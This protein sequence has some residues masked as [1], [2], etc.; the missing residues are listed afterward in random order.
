MSF[1]TKK[2]LKQG[3]HGRSVKNADEGRGDPGQ[4]RPERTDMAQGPGTKASC[5]HPEI[6]REVGCQRVEKSVEGRKLL[7]G[8]QFQKTLS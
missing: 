5:R 8:N 4:G 1:S 2:V 6:C 3:F 7:L